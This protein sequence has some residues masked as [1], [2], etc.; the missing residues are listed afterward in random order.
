LFSIYIGTVIFP[1]LDRSIQTLTLAM[2]FFV[3]PL[4]LWLLSDLVKQFEE[5][6]CES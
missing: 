3:W 2:F 1:N 5:V 6:I 4:M